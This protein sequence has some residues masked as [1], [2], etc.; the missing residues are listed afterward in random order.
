M[1]VDSDIVRRFVANP[2]LLGVCTL[3]E[4]VMAAVSQNG[5]SLKYA[6]P[7]LKTDKEVVMAAVSQEGRSLSYAHPSLKADKE[8]IVVPMRAASAS[9]A[10]VAAKGCAWLNS[11]STARVPSTVDLAAP[12][13]SSSTSRSCLANGCG[14]LPGRLSCCA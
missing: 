2:S 6:H 12:I 10:S 8:V 7:S 14:S 1:S 13:A 9:K 5:L 3:K 4:V 11:L